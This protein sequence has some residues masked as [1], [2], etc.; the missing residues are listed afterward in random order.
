M[1]FGDSKGEHDLIG[2][3]ITVTTVTTILK[4]EITPEVR[5]ELIRQIFPYHLDKTYNI[6]FPCW[7]KSLG[8]KP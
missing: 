3:S 8:V 2:L 7:L 6:C 1:L 5:R 4:P